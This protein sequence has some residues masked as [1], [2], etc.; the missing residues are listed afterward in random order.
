MKIRAR[1]GFTL[2]ELLLAVSLLSLITGSIL[3]GLHIGRRA[4]ETSRASESLDE[5]ESAL[6]AVS[7]LLSRAYPAPIAAQDASTGQILFEGRPNSCRFIMLSEG[8]AQWGGL[9]VAEIAMEPNGPAANL[10]VWTAIF[11]DVESALAGRETMA[12]TAVLKDL[13]SFQLSYFGVV[14]PGKPPVWTDAWE[15]R[16]APPRLIGV[17]IGANRLGRVIELAA[18]VATRQQ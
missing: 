5:V 9:L 13:A 17:K 6:R 1:N 11:R 2:L 18:T 3:G 12:R 16:I 4:W 15:R 14:E 7:T 8:N 10:A